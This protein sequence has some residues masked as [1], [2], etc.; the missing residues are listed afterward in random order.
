M[1]YRFPQL[2][3]TTE[4]V[5]IIQHPEHMGHDGSQY[6]NYFIGAKSSHLCFSS[7][8]N[9]TDINPMCS[10]SENRPRCLNYSPDYHRNILTN[11]ESNMLDA[12]ISNISYSNS[13]QDQKPETT[14]TSIQDVP[15]SLIKMYANITNETITYTSKGGDERD[16][17]SPPAVPRGSYRTYQQRKD[18]FKDAFHSLNRDENSRGRTGI[19]SQGYFSGSDIENLNQN[20]TDSN[21]ETKLLQYPGSLS[22]SRQKLDSVTSRSPSNVGSPGYHQ[23]KQLLR[24]RSHMKNTFSSPTN[25]IA[26]D[27]GSVTQTVP[28][29][30]AAALRWVFCCGCCG[31]NSQTKPKND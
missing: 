4:P 15:S 1:I 3:C 7:H 5:Y 12:N 26:V 22:M 25:G 28:Q 29:Q 31:N 24:P 18:M 8:T 20:L 13:Q 16:T 14:V 17:Y 30:I 21:W 27:N 23:M 9:K 2:P 11:I 19:R 10:L 6:Q